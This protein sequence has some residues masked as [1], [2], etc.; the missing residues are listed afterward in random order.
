MSEREPAPPTGQGEVVASAIRDGVLRRPSDAA[1]SFVD[2]VCAVQRAAGAS[3]PVTPHCEAVAGH[4]FDRSHLVL[5]L[6]DGMGM[7]ALGHPTMAD[8]RAHVRM[9]IDSVFPA[10]TACAMTTVA[11]GQWPGRHGVPGW[12]AYL[13][14][15]DLPVTVLPFEERRTGRRLRRHGVR[16]PDIWPQP[17]RFAE[18]TGSMEMHMP[19]KYL[20]STFNRYLSG[21][22]RTRG[23]RSL[24]HAQRRILRRM[25]AVHGRRTEP[26]VTFWYIPDYD[27]ACHTYGVA[28][29]EARTT[30]AEIRDLLMELAAGAPDYVRVAVTADHGLIDL[31]EGE[32]A[33][34]FD[35]DPLLDCLLSMPSGE[36]RTPHFHVRPGRER[37]LAERL[38]ERAGGRMAL[39]SQAEA[40][41][42]RL[43]GPAPLSEFAR[44]RFGDYVGITL[45][46][47][48]LAHYASAE[49]TALRHVGV[50]GGMCPDEVRVPLVVL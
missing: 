46:P 18:T 41:E 23:Y 34:L 15:H 6:V 29:S 33:P 17:S 21:R 44:R 7:S 31:G 28:S 24:R 22:S 40:E 10:T 49:S 36:G 12:W 32:R 50:H 3:T 42:L 39:L 38:A 43:F 35:G 27:S 37:E 4:L 11:T 14:E 16:V 19:W 26:T 1:P 9:Q 20:L 30:L 2:L 13:A 47:F 8:L 5:V 25:R 48:T 45:A